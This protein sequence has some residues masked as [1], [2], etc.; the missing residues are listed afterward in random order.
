MLLLDHYQKIVH[1]FYIYEG[2]PK[3]S[4]TTNMEFGWCI[5]DGD[6]L[7]I[8]RHSIIEETLYRICR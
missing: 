6:L 2:L 7:T 8:K 1:D 3:F 5:A 4:L